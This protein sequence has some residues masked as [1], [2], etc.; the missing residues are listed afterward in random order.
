M[1]V[2]ITINGF[3]NKEEAIEFMSWYS[4]Q[5]E[6]DI[7]FWMEC[8][9][10]EGKDVRTNIYSKNYNEETLTMDVSEQL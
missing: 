1:S 6:Q 5:G 8:R 9:K 7:E 10:H 2:S 4:N 3:K